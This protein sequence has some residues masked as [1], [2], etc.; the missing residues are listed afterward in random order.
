MCDM[1]DRR[2]KMQKRMSLMGR[3]KVDSRKVGGEG[4]LPT[5]DCMK[6]YNIEEEE[7]VTVAVKRN[8]HRKSRINAE[9]FFCWNSFWWDSKSRSF[10]V[11]FSAT[12]ISSR[13]TKYTKYVENSTLS[14]FCWAS[15]SFFRLPTTFV[16]FVRFVGWHR[17]NE[18]CK[19]LQTKQCLKS[20]KVSKCV[21]II[22]T[23]GSMCW[24]LRNII[25]TFSWWVR[26]SHNQ[27]Q[28]LVNI[29]CEHWRAQNNRESFDFTIIDMTGSLEYSTLFIW[30]KSEVVKSE[31]STGDDARLQM[32]QIYSKLEKRQHIC[33][34]SIDIG[35][36]ISKAVR[37]ILSRIPIWI[38]IEFGLQ[39]DF[40]C[41]GKKDEDFCLICK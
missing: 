4:W 36:I 14:L 37:W 16:S 29:A 19:C 31:R 34:Q 38:H 12:F 13:I 40:I 21:C 33:I 26:E 2:R 35:E 3:E 8:S 5:H 20:K 6:L 10:S 22:A 39:F 24:E 30:K 17:E 18:K 23:L 28:V 7:E 9:F 1:C 11:Q 27:A 32:L 15:H 41:M 25:R